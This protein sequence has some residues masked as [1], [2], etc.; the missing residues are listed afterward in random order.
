MELWHRSIMAVPIG[1]HLLP[2]AYW[3]DN[4]IAVS[5]VFFHEDRGG[6]MKWANSPLCGYS[7]YRLNSEDVNGLEPHPQT[8]QIW[9]TASPVPFAALT[10]VERRDNP[11]TLPGLPEM[12][13][14]RA[15][16]FGTF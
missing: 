2:M 12:V 8:P 7:L 16:E 10:L 4:D 1:T 3:H 5:F 15:R 11:T 13:E 9:R 6:A 14:A